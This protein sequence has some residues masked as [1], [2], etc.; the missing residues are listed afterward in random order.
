MLHEE[1]KK[2]ILI[3]DGAMG[4]V[5]QK[6]NLNSDDFGGKAKGCFEIL[7][8][9]RPDIIQEVHEK[10]ILAG[11]DIIETNSFNCNAISLKDYNLENKVFDLAKKSGEIAKKA[12]KISNKKIYVLGSIGPTNKSLSFPIGDIPYERAI[13]FNDLKEVYKEQIRG[14]IAGKVDGL[15]IETIFDGLNAKA[16]VLAAEEVYEE[17][18]IRLP[19]CISATV[20]RQGKLLTGQSMESLIVSLDA[21]TIIS[22][23]FNC[24]FGAADLVPLIKRIQKST[25]KF[26]SLYPNAGLPNQNGD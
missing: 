17:L 15:L 21:D 9:T 25:T 24:S 13:S 12:T 14:L 19:I 3:L 23:G 1:L 16:A 5:L 2:R 7:N 20:N 10:Y 11:A 4:T 6:Y 22:F 8:E 18:D 26:I